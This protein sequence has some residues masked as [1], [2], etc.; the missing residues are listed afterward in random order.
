MKNKIIILT[1]TVFAILSFAILAESTV[2]T[3]TGTYKCANACVV[4]ENGNVTDN[5]GGTV[6]KMVVPEAPKET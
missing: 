5:E 4:D 6:W 1:I 2:I 3:T